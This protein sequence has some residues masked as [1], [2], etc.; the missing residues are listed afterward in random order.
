MTNRDVVV[1]VS[2]SCPHCDQAID[3]SHKKTLG[4]SQT[5]FY[6]FDCPHCSEAVHHQLSADIVSVHKAAT[7][8]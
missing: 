3:V 2:M 1:L 6:R 8:R 7:R 4:F 5:G